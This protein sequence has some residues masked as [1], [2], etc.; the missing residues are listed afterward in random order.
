MLF[1]DHMIVFM[2]CSQSQYQLAF[3]PANSYF[4][5]LSCNQLM[6]NTALLYACAC[7]DFMNVQML[8]SHGTDVNY[9]HI[10]RIG[11]F[12]LLYILLSVLFIRVLY[13]IYYNKGLMCI[14]YD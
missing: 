2:L 8:I 4:K 9:N 14:T 5:I 10:T 12:I 1:Y 6:W 13:H 3:L 11:L 7:G